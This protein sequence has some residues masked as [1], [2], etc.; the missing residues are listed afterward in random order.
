[1]ITK[2]PT[3]LGNIFGNGQCDHISLDHPYS[4]LLQLVALGRGLARAALAM[5][6]ESQGCCFYQY[7]CH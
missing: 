5:Q 1:M 3:N 4:V 7:E 2:V 6:T